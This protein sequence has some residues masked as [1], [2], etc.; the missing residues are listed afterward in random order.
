MP[1]LFQPQEV[2]W[3][4]IYALTCHRQYENLPKIAYG[5]QEK[6]REERGAELLCLA[7]AR[8]ADP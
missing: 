5:S 8:S 4:Y 7:Q 6:K 1:I 2:L 3:V